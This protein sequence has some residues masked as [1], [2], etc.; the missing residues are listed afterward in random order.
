MATDI[1][2]RRY[3]FY[4]NVAEVTVDGDV[5]LKFMLGTPWGQRVSLQAILQNLSCNKAPDL[6]LEHLAAEDVQLPAVSSTRLT[7]AE[8]EAL[9]QYYVRPL[10][11]YGGFYAT[12]VTLG[13]SISMLQDPYN[14][15]QEIIKKQELAASALSKVVSQV[16][17]KVSDQKKYPPARTTFSVLGAKVCHTMLHAMIL[18]DG[19]L[20]ALQ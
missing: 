14:A 4:D 3:H 7:A 18:T 12:A 8:K 15:W 20:F 10:V 11:P 13:T 5:K 16:M 6:K 9:N 1:L 19:V 2:A 17:D